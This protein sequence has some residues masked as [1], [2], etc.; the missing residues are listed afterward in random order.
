MCHVL[1]IMVIVAGGM[2]NGT[3]GANLSFSIQLH[4]PCLSQAQE[5]VREHTAHG[6][7]MIV[8]I[9]GPEIIRNGFPILYLCFY[10]EYHAVNLGFQCLAFRIPVTVP[11]LL[12]SNRL[13]RCIYANRGQW[14]YFV[15]NV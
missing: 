3:L 5:E 12:L 6:S 9:S 13:F 11:D 2:T 15:I 14:D 1:A 10:T 8:A 4:L 7:I